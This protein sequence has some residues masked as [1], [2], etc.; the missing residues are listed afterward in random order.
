M[1][2]NKYLAECGVASRRACDKLI[3]DGK[4]AVNGK[5]CKLGYDVDEKN[6]V[7]TVE[8]QKVSPAAVHK[9]YLMN[10]PKG[11]V[12]TVK[13]DKGRKTVMDLLPAN[14]GRVYPVGRLD[15]DSEGMLLFTDDGELAFRLT[16]PKNE[17]QKT[18]LVRI[19][20]EV[21][22]QLLN[23]LR[24]GVELDGKRTGKSKIKIV[25][26]DKKYTKLHVTIGE[27]RNRQV[28]RMFESIGKEVVFL[29]RIRIGEMGLGSLERGKV[30]SLSAEEIF[31]LKN[32]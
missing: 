23:K 17:I 11:Y 4:V 22:E 19:E 9:Y 6:D 5:P 30:R 26:T 15:Y 31:Y 16:H 10:K 32:L 8:G 28:R 21:S 13:D 2:I 24:A 14:A 18:Y 7:V 12:C 3:E 25:E 20:G 29:K 27:G 1:R